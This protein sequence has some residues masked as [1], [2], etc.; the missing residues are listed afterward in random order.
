M[1]R[2]FVALIFVFKASLCFGWFDEIIWSVCLVRDK[3][4]FADATKTLVDMVVL[5]AK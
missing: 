3:P 4:V 2:S 5:N 1:I